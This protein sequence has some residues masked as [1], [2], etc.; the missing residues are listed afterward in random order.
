[1]EKELQKILYAEDDLDIQT[2]T[3][4]ALESFGNFTLKQCN[5]GKQA[6]DC[7]DEF[8]PDIVVTD[9]MMPE[10]DGITLLQ[11]LR[12]NPKYKDLPVI[13]TTAKAQAHEIE[14]YSKLGVTKI[15]S[16]PFNL[17]TLADELREIWRAYTTKSL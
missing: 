7:I 5:N 13:F 12:N 1:M 6:L 8:E 3:I 17:V 4:M 11:N 10:M 16:K 15:I 14:Y 9:I 2:I